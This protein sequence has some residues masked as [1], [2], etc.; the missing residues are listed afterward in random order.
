MNIVVAGDVHGAIG[1]LY[2]RAHELQDKD[3]TRVD[4]I[5]Q[6]GDLQIYSDASQ[7]DKAVKKHGG[8]G[9]FPAWLR[10]GR[11][12][13]IPTYTIL[14]NHDDAKLFYEYAGREILPSL[15]LLQQGE[16]SSIVIGGQAIRVGALGGNYSPRY[17]KVT[18][19][20]L[21][22]GKLKHY[23]EN[24]LAKLV[25]NAPFDILLVH[26]APT[27]FVTRDGVDLGRPEVRDLIEHT[28]PRFVFFG[29]HHHHVEGMIGNT[30]VIGLAGVQRDGG[31]YVLRDL[32]FR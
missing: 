9:E 3:G 14:G 31:L 2:E 25:E 22:T 6:V 20:E 19:A 8:V 13:P 23:T 27:G 30:T 17:F 12:A 7:V 32:R 21:P 4:A 1:A 28:Q 29:H 5:F 10:E 24:H 16:I 26:E 15:H 11:R 18:P